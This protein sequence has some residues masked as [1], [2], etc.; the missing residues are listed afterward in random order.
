ML[1][2]EALTGVLKQS[3]DQ[4][5]S[6]KQNKFQNCQSGSA[7]NSLEKQT[8]ERPIPNALEGDIKTSEENVYLI[9]H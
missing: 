1:V 7:L 6:N 4:I 3:S 5:V 2:H 8:L 9:S